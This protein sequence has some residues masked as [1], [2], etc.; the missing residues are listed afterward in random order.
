MT[1]IRYTLMDPTGNR[2]VLVETPVPASRQPQVAAFLMQCE[3]DAEQVGFLQSGTNGADIALRM[4]GG[5]FCAN[6]TMSAAA[7][8]AHRHGLPVCTVSVQVS[9]AA[10]PVAVHLRRQDGGAWR[11]AVEMPRPEAIRQVSFDD[12]QTLPVV[13]LP[14][15]AHV[16]LENILPDDTA[17][18]RAGA[19]CAFLGAEAV[20]LMYLDLP[21]QA[22]RPLVYVPAAG[23]LFWESACGSGTSAVGAYLAHQSGKPV[24]IALRQPGG[25]LG[26]KASADG[27]LLLEGG[28]KF[29]HQKAVG[30]ETE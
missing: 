22:L 27:A 19:M 25:V 3:P 28:T 8:W 14:G 23:T 21:A 4:A 2:T 15:I 9:G 7:I 26:V 30:C 16:I 29:V 1:Q 18:T 17:Q 6:A 12:G 20:G 10:E 13:F 24:H 5:E 11:A